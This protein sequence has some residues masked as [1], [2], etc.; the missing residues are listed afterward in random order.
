MNDGKMLFYGAIIAM[1]CMT[2]MITNC[3]YQQRA[4]TSEAIKAG[5]KT[6]DIKNLCNQNR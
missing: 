4:C 6:E 3:S 5:I 2:G 1:F